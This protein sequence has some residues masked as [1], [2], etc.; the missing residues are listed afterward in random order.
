M[1]I[2]YTVGNPDVYELNLDMRAHQGRELCKAPGGVAYRTQ[3]EAQAELDYHDGALPP[4]W[5]D[6][7]Q[8]RPGRVYGIELPNSWEQDTRPN[9]RGGYQITVLAPIFRLRGEP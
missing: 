3:E 1:E 4:H 9:V 8:H 6:D 7:W 5:F 2:A